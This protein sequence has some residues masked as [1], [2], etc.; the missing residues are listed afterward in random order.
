MKWIIASLLLSLSAP[1]VAMQAASTEQVFCAGHVVVVAQVK[2]GVSEDCRLRMAAPCLQEHGMRLSVTVSEVLAVKKDW[3]RRMYE[4]YDP[5]FSPRH[6]MELIGRTLDLHVDTGAV[7]WVTTT[8]SERGPDNDGYLDAPTAEP[9]TDADIRSLYGGKSFIFTMQPSNSPGDPHWSGAWPMNSR[10]WAM[11]LMRQRA[12]NQCPALLLGQ[13]GPF[14]GKPVTDTS[15]RQALISRLEVQFAHVFETEPGYPTV[16]QA[17]TSAREL[18]PDLDD[19]SWRKMSTEVDTMVV[20][21]MTA[22]GTGLD[23][24]LR[25][26]FDT[27]STPELKRLSGIF[28][29]P[30]FNQFFTALIS[31][32]IEDIRERGMDNERTALP[33]A[34]RSV[35]E[36]HGLKVPQ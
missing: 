32:E 11:K 34:M 9:L 28:A 4:T 13:G 17:L 16:E 23:L 22:K 35:L 20:S 31:S 15:Y 6:A 26:V 29:D 33:R 10:M 30:A 1:A 12:G 3:D 18:N 24:A 5:S 8:D 25:T 21:L 2:E 19:A 27:L 14:S 36:E 7:P